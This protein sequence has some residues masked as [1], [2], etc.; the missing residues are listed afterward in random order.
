MLPMTWRANASQ[1][2]LEYTTS[3]DAS[4][5]TFRPRVTAFYDVASSICQSISSSPSLSSSY[6]VASS[7][8]Q[9]RLPGRAQQGGA[10]R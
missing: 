6:D 1:I 4:K 2:L 5:R 8:C 7:V 10:A 3:Q 9:A